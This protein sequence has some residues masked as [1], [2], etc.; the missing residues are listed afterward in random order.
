V[1][2]TLKDGNELVGAIADVEY[3]RGRAPDAPVEAMRST[4]S[5]RLITEGDIDMLDVTSIE[6]CPEKTA[7]RVALLR[8]RGTTRR[9]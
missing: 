1:R 8:F 5:I 6:S 9:P 7:V 4:G 3:G 2:V